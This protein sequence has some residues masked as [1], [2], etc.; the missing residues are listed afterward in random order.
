MF[1]S[2][3]IATINRPTLARSVQSVLDQHLP[4]NEFEVI[5]VNDSGLPLAPAEWQCSGRVQV[6][7]TVQRERCVARNAGAAIARGK[8]LHFLDDDDL[9]CPG[10]LEAFW[11]LAQQTRAEG[12][13]G[14]YQSMTDNGETL[15]E[16]APDVQGNIFHVLLAGESIPFQASLL[17]APLFFRVG[18]FDPK[19]RM[20]EDRDLARRFALHGMFARTGRVVA[21]I[22]VGEGGS[23]MNGRWHEGPELDRR[24]R[25]KAL[26]ETG[27]FARVRAASPSSYW[28]GRVSRAYFA[29]MGWNIKQKRFATA[30]SRGVFGT[31]MAGTE[32]VHREFWH[33]LRT[34]VRDN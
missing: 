3:I 15:G 30:L 24:G 25:E 11:T 2:T 33:G 4:M 20:T 16:F 17:D 1:S 10:A 21:R 18:G 8:Y 13:Y 32:F 23:S 19:L 9:L 34:R 27:A 5:V 31:L 12:L 14:A 29:S 28:R 22:R 26:A 6:I 7:N